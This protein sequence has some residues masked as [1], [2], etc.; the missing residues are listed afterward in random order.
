MF[1]LRKS[2]QRGHFNHGWLETRHTFSF[3]QYRDPRYMRFRDLRVINQD[4]VQAGQG[5]SAHQHT[6]ME[7]LTYVL[8][9]AVTH[10]DSMGNKG[11]IKPGEIQ[12]MSAGTGVTHS[13]FNYE[14]EDL[15]LLQI[16][17]FPETKDLS[18]SY[19][20]VKYTTPHNQLILIASSNPEKNAV[21]IHQGVKI[22]T[23]QLDA[24]QSLNYELKQNRYA[25]LQLISGELTINQNS[26]S[27]GDGIAISQEEKIMIVANTTSTF[28]L[29]DLR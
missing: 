7:I 3:D 23:G 28:L 20:Q 17:I 12:R 10:Q 5:F 25:W 24:K 22:Y 19:E 29:F 2:E 14:N 8:R 15:E 11:I 13:E 21:L 6:N 1:A 4:I 27:A 16:W 18:P 9:G 26:L